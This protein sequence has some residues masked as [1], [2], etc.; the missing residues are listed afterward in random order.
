MRDVFSSAAVAAC[1]DDESLVRAMLAFECALAEAQAEVGLI[2]ASAAEPIRDAANAADFDY[3]ELAREARRAGTIAIPLVKH[4]TRIVASQDEYA[5]RYV[6]FGVTSQDVQ[7]SALVLQLR[8]ATIVLL[9]VI[10]QLGDALA[11]L[12]ERHRD[13]PTV[14]RTLLQPATPVPFGWKVAVWLDAVTR[15]R[16][17]LAVAAAQACVL[18]FGGASGVRSAIGP[19]G[20]AIAEAVARKLD[21]ALPTVPWHSVRDRVA[22]V[23]SE[24]GIVCSIAGKI[25][26]DVALLM[27]PEIG[28]VREP[29][30]EGRGGSSALPH[31]RNPVG[32]M[33]AREAA[34]RAPGLVATLIA[35]VAG[36][37]E[38][39]LGQWQG[40]AWTL[41]DLYAATGSAIEAIVDVVEGLDVDVDAMRR[42]LDAT[43]GLVY[44]EALSIALTPA[45]GKQAAHKRV[46][47]LCQRV[48]TDKS[49]LEAT[50]ADDRELTSIV[51]ASA[52]A[53]LFD[54]RR[55]FGAAA[56]M[57]DAALKAWR[58]PEDRDAVS[59]A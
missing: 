32:A 4:F 58:H 16:S 47:A 7:D 35:S 11:T 3:A 10:D 40:Q 41:R 57:I 31:K 43:R 20:D 49:T 48:L 50:V 27:Q 46:E 29:A 42:N 44:A 13:T 36:E 54:P 1:F 21:L 55:Q 33:T 28:E 30:G 23:A 45:L 38:R 51:D 15:S 14:A 53:A 37:H 56:A 19:Q 25:A 9:A 59:S 17:Q 26:T 12:A 8:E 5:A 39:G 6:H 52:R 34:L 2:P 22:R 18:Q 24:I